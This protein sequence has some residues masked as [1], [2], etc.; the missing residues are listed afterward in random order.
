LLI[1]IEKFEDFIANE[2][3]IGLGSFRRNLLQILDGG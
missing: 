1:A 2:F 3:G